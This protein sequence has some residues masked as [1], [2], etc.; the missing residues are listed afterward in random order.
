M[1]LINDYELAKYDIPIRAWAVYDP[2]AKKAGN[3]VFKIRLNYTRN[4]YSELSFKGEE[5]EM[6]ARLFN[7]Y[8]SWKYGMFKND[9]KKKLDKL[10]NLKHKLLSKK[11]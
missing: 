9:P 11:K 7:G 10:L 1:E 8:H 5:L 2:L 3:K 6:Y 4:L